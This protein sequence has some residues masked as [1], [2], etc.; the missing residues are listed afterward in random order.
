MSSVVAAFY[1]DTM[2]IAALREKVAGE[3]VCNWSL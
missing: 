1:Y 3:D 2:R